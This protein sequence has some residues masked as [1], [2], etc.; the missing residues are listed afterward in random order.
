VAE[1]QL[2][3]QAEAESQLLASSSMIELQH[4]EDEAV[5]YA[6]ST[7]PKNYEQVVAVL[8]SMGTV[9]PQPGQ[10]PTRT[11]SNSPFLGK[12]VEKVEGEKTYTECPGNSFI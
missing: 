2:D 9:E 1:G 11:V 3:Q 5:E 10:I 7:A 6:R 8:S 12:T 4:I